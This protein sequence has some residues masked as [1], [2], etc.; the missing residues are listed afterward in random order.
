MPAGAWPM[1]FWAIQAFG[2]EFS[3]IEYSLPAALV[4]AA[5]GDR[6]GDDHPVARLDLLDRLAGLDDL[7][8]EFMAEDVARLHRRD[9]AVVEVQV[10]AADRRR[11]DPDDRVAGR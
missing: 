9:E 7:A 11:G 2:L 8:H 1:S 4:A 10:G 3:Q 5:A 6:E